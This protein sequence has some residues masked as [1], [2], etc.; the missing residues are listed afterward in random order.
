MEEHKELLKK[1][2]S[3]MRDTAQSCTV[4]AALI[5]TMVFTASFTVPGGNNQDTG[6]PIFLG[7]PAFII[8]TMSGA[9]ALFSSITSVLAFTVILTSS[10]LVEDFVV[11]LPLK[12]IMGLVSLTFAAACMMVA[13][14]AAIH[15]VLSHHFKLIVIPVSLLAIFPILFFILLQLPLLVNMLSTTF[16]NAHLPSPDNSYLRRPLPPPPL[17]VVNRLK[18]MFRRGKDFLCGTKKGSS[19]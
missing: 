14:C 7:T 10:Y 18:Q 8:F 4:V 17:G 13:F 5:A 15:M 16:G 19:G 1:A 6:I 2:E 9:M 12:M 11:S 3:W